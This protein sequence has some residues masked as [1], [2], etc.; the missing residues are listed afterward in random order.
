MRP[1]D[2]WSCVREWGECPNEDC[3]PTI[4]VPDRNVGKWIPHP[5]KEFKEWDVCTACGIGT[6]RR[7]ITSEYVSEESYH[8]CP[9]CGARMEVSDEIN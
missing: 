5:N 7:E 6:K 9:H 1:K 4:D 3:D 8:Y 2:C